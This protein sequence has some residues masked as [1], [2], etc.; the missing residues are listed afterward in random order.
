MKIKLKTYLL[1]FLLIVSAFLG[2][3]AQDKKL[4]SNITEFNEAVR[5]AKPGTQ[6]VMATGI[7]KDVE[8]LF[9]AHGTEKQPIQLIRFVDLD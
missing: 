3:K 9:E 4:V 2:V 1:L 8:L 6:I 5:Q 7:W